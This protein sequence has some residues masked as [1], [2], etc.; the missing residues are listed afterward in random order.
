MRLDDGHIEVMDD[1][2]TEIFKRKTP[3][4]RLRIAFGLWHSARVQMYNCIRS[5]HPEWDEKRV[6]R[7]VV[8]R[9]SHGAI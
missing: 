3:T 8:R 5:L 1:V 2:M 6:Q 7:E 4:E 9:I